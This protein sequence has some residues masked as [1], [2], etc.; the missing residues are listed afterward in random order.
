METSMVW[1]VGLT[2]LAHR[3]S[4]IKKTVG[5]KWPDSFKR[6]I[7]PVPMSSLYN[8]YFVFSCVIDDIT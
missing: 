1:S 6:C 8:I 7:G 3:A 4:R 2:P 5:P